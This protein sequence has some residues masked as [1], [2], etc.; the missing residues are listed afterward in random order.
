MSGC[1]A[2]SFVT[3]SFTDTRPRSAMDKKDD[4]AKTGAGHGYL[5]PEVLEWLFTLAVV[6]F[7]YWQSAA[8]R[9][10]GFIR[11]AGDRY[12]EAVELKA[13]MLPQAAGTGRVA[14]IC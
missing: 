14:G 12:Q 7:L 9:D 6:A 4:A 8:F 13:P 10:P 1:R 2:N 11:G 5:A 3:I